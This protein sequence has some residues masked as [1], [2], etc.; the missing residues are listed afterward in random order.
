MSERL[1]KIGSYVGYLVGRDF[2]PALLD[3]DRVV[4]GYNLIELSDQS[5]QYAKKISPAEAAALLEYSGS[6][7]VGPDDGD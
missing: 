3:D 5:L 7:T 4:Q 2:I 6:S 1:V